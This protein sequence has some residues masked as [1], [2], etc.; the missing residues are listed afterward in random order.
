MGGTDDTDHHEVAKRAEREA[1]ELERR[2]DSLEKDVEEA[3][4]SWEQKRADPG[5]PGAKP[6]ERETE[7]G[8][9]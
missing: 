2:S 1:N 8:E 5:V 4:R 3:R 6:P 9:G 7:R